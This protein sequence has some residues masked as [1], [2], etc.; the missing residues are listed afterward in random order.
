[1][2]PAFAIAKL[3]SSGSESSKLQ[4]V[5]HGLRL[6][7]DENSNRI[8]HEELRLNYIVD[9][10]EADFANKLVDEINGELP[11]ISIISAEDLKKVANPVGFFWCNIF[12][13]VKRLNIVNCFNAPFTF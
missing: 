8:S 13:W 11:A 6:P 1:M 3:C 7:V 12:F 4:E 5:G 9:V 10:T 2:N